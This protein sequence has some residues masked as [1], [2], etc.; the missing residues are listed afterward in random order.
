MELPDELRAAITL[1]ASVDEALADADLAVIATEWPEFRTLTAEQFAR[2]MR[3]PCVIDQ[4]HFLAKSLA[5]D[6]RIAYVATGKATNLPQVANAP[7]PHTL[8]PHVK[9]ASARC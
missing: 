9:P 8:K 3:A 5:A 6:G 1:C 7:G 4:N 2:L